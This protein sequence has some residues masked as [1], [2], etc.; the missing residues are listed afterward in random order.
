MWDSNKRRWPVADY[1][2]VLL[3]S[4]R[5]IQLYEKPGT[6]YNLYN[7]EEYV[8]RQAGNAISTW[9][10]IHQDDE[11]FK[12]K[13]QQRATHVNPKYRALVDQYR[14][15]QKEEAASP[16]GAPAKGD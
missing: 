2:A 14:V 4:A 9:L 11:L 12:K 13:L 1:W 15:I 6:D 3:G 8:F 16:M 10:E 7:L 5:R